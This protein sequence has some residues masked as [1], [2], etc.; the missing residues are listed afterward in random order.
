MRPWRARAV[1]AGLV[2]ATAAVMPAWAL[3]QTSAPVPARPAA[4]VAAGAPML[5]E[6]NPLQC[7]WRTSSGAVRQGEVFDVTLTC[8]V[9]DTDALGVVP[10]ETR[11]TVAAVQLAPFEIVDGGRAPDVREGDW[12]VFQYR[13]RLRNGRSFPEG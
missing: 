1:E 6:A 2:V 8:A 12:R 9:L 7:W 13:Y 10:E 11:L 5:S 4:A 3:A